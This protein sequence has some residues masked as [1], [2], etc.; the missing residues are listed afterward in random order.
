MNLWEIFLTWFEILNLESCL[1]GRLH[2]PLHL[3]EISVLEPCLGMDDA[4]K[5]RGGRTRRADLVFCTMDF[6][7]R[8]LIRGIQYFLF[9][10]LLSMCHFSKPASS[11]KHLAVL[12]GLSWGLIFAWKGK[13]E[14]RL[15]MM[16]NSD[17]SI[18]FVALTCSG[19]FQHQLITESS[20][21]LHVLLFQVSLLGR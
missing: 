11:C 7:G 10:A 17:C 15:F 3:F 8:D 9:K 1:A 18:S 19:G 14:L 5:L 16:F 12:V 13:A 21:F 2:K 4:F 20:A 6:A